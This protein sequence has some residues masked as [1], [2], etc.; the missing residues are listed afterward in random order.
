MLT[1]IQQVIGKLG[2]SLANEGITA[3]EIESMAGRNRF[4]D[5]IPYRAYDPQDHYYIN[6]DDA[7]G[8]LWETT[9]LVYAAADTH[10][11]I[12]QILKTVPMGSIL[13]VI[14]YAD[15]NIEPIIQHYLA[16]RQRPNEGSHK[17]AQ[18]TAE[19]FEKAAEHGFAQMAGI[20]ARHFRC[21]VALKLKL[22]NG[23]D[24]DARYLRDSVHEVLNGCGLMPRYLQPQALCLWL[25]RL[26]ND[27]A[28]IPNPETWRYNDQLPI[29][30][31]IIMG[32]TTTK[33]GFNT[34]QLGTEKFLSCQTI[35]EYPA[36]SLDDLTMNKVVGGLWGARDDGNQCNFPILLSTNIIVEDMRHQFHGKTTMMMYQEKKGSGAGFK[37][38]R[39]QEFQWAAQETDRGERFVRVIPSI[40]IFSRTEKEASENTA[41]TKRLWENQGFAV[42]KDRGILAPLFLLSLPFGLYNTKNNIEFLERDRIMPTKSAA[43]M[44]PLQADFSGFGK[45]V[46][47]LVGRKGQIIP[48]DMFNEHAPNRNAIISA[49][50]GSGKS[51]LMNRL[52]TDQL[53][54]GVIVR[55]FDLGGSYKKLAEIQQGNFIYFGRDSKVCVNPYSTIRQIDEEIGIL[56]L[57]VSQMVWSSS[58]D[59]PNETQMTIIKTASRQVWDDYG[60]DGR[61]DL[62]RQ[63]LLD[64]DECLKKQNC[65]FADGTGKI[66]EMAKE[67]A[68][69]LGDFTDNGPYARWFNGKSTL[70]IEQDRFIVL[71]LEELIAMEELFNVVI[72][73]I[74]NYVTQNLYLSDRSSPRTIVFD[75][76]WKWFKE[77]SFLGEIVENGYRLARKYYGAFITIFQSMLDLRKFG[78]SG[79]VLNENSAF[80]FFLMARSKYGKMQEEKLLDLDPFMLEIANSVRLE[81]GRYS[82]VLIQTPMN[83]GVARLPADP[84]SHLVF[85]SDPRENAIINKLAAQKGISK[86]N[87]IEQLLS[88]AA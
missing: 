39:Q 66:N 12:E 47:L 82:E 38:D 74:V 3:H 61:I 76:A 73:Q 62:V 18:Q 37:M 53:S 32:G 25:Q 17:I 41:R 46:T 36:E 22:K 56:S 2:H 77:G 80:K 63:V 15:K 35:K 48:L 79:D 64:F 9:P 59:K 67:L 30:K 10:D 6:A 8:I 78:K 88:E 72:M 87:A 34:L 57:I 1:F 65:K 4:S 11:M 54:T 81:K 40:V 70:N 68:F 49:T 21:F 51:Y 33:I 83:T 58:K 55:V 29:N 19:L 16:L 23:F 50:T 24:N 75:E 84:F 69:N 31:Q 13:Q 44:V 60:N 28:D 52:L 45:P 86:I 43:R 5:Y 42:N 85:T 14:L 71:E 7:Y 26:F 27:R 20:P